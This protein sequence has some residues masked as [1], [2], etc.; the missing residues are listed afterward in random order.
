FFKFRQMAQ[1]QFENRFGLNIGER[2]T[3]H[4]FLLRLLLVTNDRDD[5]IDIEEGNQIT[6]EDVQP[7][8]N[9]I[10]TELQTFAR[11][12]GAELQPLGQN[13]LQRF[14]L[15]ATVEADHVHVDAIGSFKIGGSEQMLHHIVEI[16]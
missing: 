1:L 15:R 14:D 4:Q 9:F 13:V 7:R 5:F 10:E 12:V 16:D 11:S 8:E 3:L 2:K 6:V